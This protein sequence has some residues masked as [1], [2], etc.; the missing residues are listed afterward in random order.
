MDYKMRKPIHYSAACENSGCLKLLISK[1]V[2]IREGDRYKNTPIM[3]AAKYGRLENV[4]LILSTITNEIERTA[5]LT[6]KSREG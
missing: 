2:D 6:K 1:G 4:K 5:I 3:I